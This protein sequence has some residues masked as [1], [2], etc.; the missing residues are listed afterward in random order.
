MDVF[1]E[2]K[3]ERILGGRLVVGAEEMRRETAE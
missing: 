3:D 2:E 1:S